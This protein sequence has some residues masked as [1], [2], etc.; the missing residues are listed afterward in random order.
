MTATSSDES[1]FTVE[2][3][4][5]GLVTLRTLKAGD[6]ELVLNQDGDVVDSRPI[7]LKYP[8]RIAFSL[9]LKADEPDDIVPA[10]VDV[11]LPVRLL[12]GRNARLAVHVF[13]ADDNE[14]F[15]HCVAGV[16]PVDT[17][18]TAGL[19]F[20]G[21]NSFI[22]LAPATDAEDTLVQINV[23]GLFN[24]DVE[25]LVASQATLEQI[26][27]LELDPGA[28][29]TGRRSLVLAQGQDVQGLMLLGAPGWSL[30]GADCGIGESLTY[31]VKWFENHELVAR[32]GNVEARRQIN[33][34]PATASWV[35]VGDSCAATGCAVP[36]MLLGLLRRRR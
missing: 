3:S 11:P 9:E 21:P 32:I 22:E 25:A 34:F 36:L 13:A 20:D 24:V 28:R 8:A 15:G 35:R 18:W 23:G 17:R 14:L 29:F 1:I 26:T 10:L 5:D 19:I 2:S 27:V 7:K 30:E 4:I 16:A 33:A 6:A 31:E 12:A